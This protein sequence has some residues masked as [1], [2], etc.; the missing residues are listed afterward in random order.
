MPSNLAWPK[1]FSKLQ[2]C[3]LPGD[4]ESFMAQ[5]SKTVAGLLPK[6]DEHPIHAAI[7]RIF[8]TVADTKIMRTSCP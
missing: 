1:F 7:S 8:G 3:E 5:T 2:V 4:A 6:G